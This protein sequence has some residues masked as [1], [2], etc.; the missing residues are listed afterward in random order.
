MLQALKALDTRID[1]CLGIEF[2]STLPIFDPWTPPAWVP[3][4]AKG[5]FDLSTNARCFQRGYVPEGMWIS[6][7]NIVNDCFQHRS[8]V[9]TR[10]RLDTSTYD[11]LVAITI[12]H[13][14]AIAGCMVQFRSA[15]GKTPYLYIMS[16]GTTQTYRGKGL[17]QQMVHAVYTL[18]TLMIEQSRRTPND[19]NIPNKHLYIALAVTLHQPRSEHDRIQ[20]IYSKCGLAPCTPD[21]QI[22]DFPAYMPYQ[23]GE[24]WK[25]ITN[26]DWTPMYTD[27]TPDVIYE[28]DS[29]RIYHPNAEQQDT[30]CHPFPAEKYHAV[31]QHGI[32]PS[33]HADLYP[34]SSGLYIAPSIGFST[35]PPD[36]G[37]VFRIKATSTASIILRIAVPYWFAAEITVLSQING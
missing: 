1:R 36:Q 21:Q 7:V 11:F 30:M 14:E 17:A 3:T 12:D 5:C 15:P 13:R 22:L 28:D 10:A 16:L 9:Q 24:D 2:T 6:Y 25:L 8:C 35:T 19:F 29:V 31:A 32:V 37:G 23:C 34:D 27:V 20:Q 4:D 18:G 26:R 33:R